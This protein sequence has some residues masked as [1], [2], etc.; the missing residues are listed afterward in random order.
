[1]Q[2]VPSISTNQEWLCEFASC[3]EQFVPGEDGERVGRELWHSM[4]TQWRADRNSGTT[5][6]HDDALEEANAWYP[7]GIC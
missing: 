2:Y 5:H 6:A 7:D 1:M 4:T 3:F